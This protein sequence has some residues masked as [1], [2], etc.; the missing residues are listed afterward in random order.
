MSATC[1]LKQSN[2][3]A[4]LP[5][6][7]ITYAAP[8]LLNTRKTSCI[9]YPATVPII[10][11]KQTR[12]AGTLLP[13]RI[14]NRLYLQIPAQASRN[15]LRLASQTKNVSS[16]RLSTLLLLLHLRVRRR[17][18]RNQLLPDTAKCSHFSIHCFLYYHLLDISE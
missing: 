9:V 10:D 15:S 8:S 6:L 3:N 5:R 11:C 17:L 16:P 1:S 7:R 2:Y 13:A 4:S 14:L 18:A 12:R